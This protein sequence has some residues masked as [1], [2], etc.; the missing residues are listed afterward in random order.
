MI[1]KGK[2][3]EKTDAMVL[4]LQAILQDQHFN[5]A[6]ILGGIIV[7]LVIDHAVIYA[8]GTNDLGCY[9]ISETV[10]N[11]IVMHKLAADRGITTFA[12]TIPELAI[13]C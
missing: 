6:V 10:N 5:A 13:V 11:I 8:L 7:V 4:R 2:S 3:G 1:N 12:M 9:G